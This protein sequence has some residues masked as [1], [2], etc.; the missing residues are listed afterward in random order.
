MLVHMRVEY[1]LPSL[2]HLLCN[3]ECKCS[4]N[5]ST[6]VQ[7]PPTETELLKQAQDAKTLTHAEKLLAEQ[8]DEVKAMNQMMLYSKCV[9]IR[10]AQLEVCSQVES[11]R[12]AECFYGPDA[13]IPLHAL[14]A[15]L[16]AH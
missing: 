11:Q 14:C 12:M 6:C 4:A 5:A 9:T 7:L 2:A 8:E 16:H 13:C 10:D 3:V 15:S 1:I